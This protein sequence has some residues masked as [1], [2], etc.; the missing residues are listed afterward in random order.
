MKT[1]SCC[2]IRKILLALPCLAMSAQGVILVNLDAGDLPLGLLQEWTNTG[3]EPG[4]FTATGTPMVMNVDGVRCVTLDGSGQFYTGPIAPSLVTGVNPNRSIEV[5]AY[6]PTIAAEETLVA[7]GKRGGGDGTNLAFNYGNSGA[8]G[9]V[10]HWGAPDLGWVNAGGAPSARDWHYL[11]YTYD[12]GGADGV[13]TTRVYADGVLMNS[14]VLGTLDTY[15]GLPFRLGAQSNADG[16]AEGFNSGLSMA[17]V[18][19]RDTVLSPAE[20]A[21]THTSERAELNPVSTAYFDGYRIPSRNSF[22]FTLQDRVPSSVTVPTTFTAAVGDIRAGWQVQGGEGIINGSITTPPIVI[23]NGGPVELSLKHRYNFE[24]DLYDGGVVMV[25]ING[26]EFVMLDG[27]QFTQNGYADGVLVGNGVLQN[28]RAW[29]AGS[30]GFA[31]GT[32]ITS[33]A[34]I[35]GVTS[36]NTIQ[37]R[38]LGAWD[39]AFTS[40]GI[41]W[42]I[43]GVTVKAGAAT[44][45]NEDFSTGN[46]GFTVEATGG[47]ANFSYISGTPPS[48]GALQASKS[49]ETT[50]FTL[51]INWTPG[52]TY[53]FTLSGK[54]ASGADLVYAIQIPAPGLTLS[55]ARQW[56]AVLPGPL[57]TAGR[58]GVRTYLNEGIDGSEN[59]DA[60]LAFLANASDRTPTLTPTTVVDTQEPDLSFKDQDT[61]AA[62]APPTGT[63]RDFPGEALSRSTNGDLSRDDNH[64]I[65]VAHGSIQISE[66]SDYSFS[67]RGDDGFFFRVT[68]A[69]GPQPQFLAVDGG[70]QVDTAARN[71]LYYANGTG[72]TNTRAAMHLTPGD[73]NLEYATWEGGGGFWYQ[74]A[75]AKGFVL[76]AADTAT[77][78]TIGYVPTPAPLSMVGQWA[79]DST[80][81]GV[82]VGSNASADASVDAA[83]A[84]DPV[85]ARSFWN[86][87]NFQD[88]GGGGSSERI[89][90][91]AIFPRLADDAAND[92]FA[93]RAQGTL[94][95]PVEGDYLIGF[96]GDDGSRLKIGGD[97]PGFTELTENFTGA[98]TIGRANTILKNQGSVGTAGDFGFSTS[99]VFSK[100]GVLK[101]NADKAIGLDAADAAKTSVLYT[102]GLN[103]AGDFSTEI[104]VKPGPIPG[105]LTCIYSSGNFGDPR[106]GWLIYM[107][108][109]NGWSFRG[110][111]NSGLATAFD[112]ATENMAPVEDQWYHIV[113]TW[114]AATGTASLYVDGALAKTLSGITNFVPTSAPATLHGRFHIG[115]RA[116][117]AFGWTGDADEAAIYP[118]TLSASVIQ[119]HFANANDAGRAVPYETLVSG[120]SPLGYWRLNETEQPRVELGGLHYDAALGGDSSTVGKIHLKAG[121]Y[122]I[123][124]LYWEAGGGASFEI[125][126][127]L[128]TDTPDFRALAN[129]VDFSGLVLTAPP[130]TGIT[131]PGLGSVVPV[132]SFNA[133]NTFSITFKSL[134]GAGYT[135]E[136]SS[137]LTTWQTILGNIA[138]TGPSTTVTG[139]AGGFFS[140]SPG[141][142]KRFFRI[143]SN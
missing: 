95:I 67:L 6:N 130:V 121:D 136:G 27:G 57:G 71:I 86:E 70:S 103:P 20:I 40:P 64:V 53:D 51:P 44:V 5:W 84:A 9:A 129:P 126:A 26:G 38:F 108:P 135:L 1:H 3:T 109:A 63:L 36:G 140:Y 88:D 110:Y 34:T 122:P 25:S 49:G 13:G 50:T 56:P 62:T 22:T 100:D 68:A 112:M 94:R 141:D 132:L 14:E 99:A 55:P 101:G 107:D 66:E 30:P 16:N 18:R 118:S 69:V 115:S 39:D 10:G 28:M 117:G 8:F 43:T 52:I 80:L 74:V 54:S 19:I 89:G 46:G 97:N 133:D 32:L 137:N 15:D 81:P 138:A 85:A 42:E 37:L 41:D 111:A 92:N 124:A 31:S 24:P 98:S 72:D 119:S 61:N 96:Q 76:N 35:P 60:M 33:V 116:D 17:R 73:Y 11:V 29:N 125:F 2:F 123:S 142:P 77:L 87:I 128:D 106:S 75:A 134:A 114:E 79:V 12:G 93:L 113:S 139:T 120:A 90:G 127:A 65:S 4:N 23:P 82:A 143:K 102:P 21:A 105:A 59:L 131:D 78:R 91:S 104:W 48:L 47:G 58:W 83:I 7:W 45:L